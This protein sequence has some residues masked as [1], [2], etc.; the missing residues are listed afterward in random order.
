MSTPN[1]EEGYALAIVPIAKE[2][3]DF[4]RARIPEGADFGVLLFANPV[5][6]GGEGR[7]VAVTSDRERV[8]FYAAQWALDVANHNPD[9]PR[10]RI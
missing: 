6:R 4:V 8:A 2:I 9:T 3:A 1:T 5:E 10:G 7:I